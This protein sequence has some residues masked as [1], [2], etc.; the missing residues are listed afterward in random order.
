MI[1]EIT[2]K[3]LG[4]IISEIK[5]IKTKYLGLF[6]E[7]I[8]FI[9]MLD[10]CKKLAKNWNIKVIRIIIFISIV[11]GYDCIDKSKENKNI[12]R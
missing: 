7:V 11:E 9:K 2:I 6:N 8:Y 10:S 5:S 1:N 3:I 4:N 12:N